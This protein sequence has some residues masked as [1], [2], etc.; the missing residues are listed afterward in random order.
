MRNTINIIS[1]LIIFSA[2][3]NIGGTTNYKVDESKSYYKEITRLKTIANIGEYNSE[4]TILVDFSIHSGKKR[5]FL[6]N[7]KSSKIEKSFLVAHGEGCN[8]NARTPSFSNTVGSLC[9][10]EGFGVL[11]GRAYSGWG[12]HIK[13]W[14]D[15]L[16]SSN[17][18][19]RRRVVVLHS[20]E[21]IPDEETYPFTI[22]KSQGC[23]TVSNNTMRYLDNLIKTQNNK[24]ILIYSFK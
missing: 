23:F 20:W 15:G 16:E 12:I 4:Y 19:M 11:G 24:K 21:G 22:A 5:M 7:L 13:Y 1:L 8:S 3:I 2:Y 10:S 14:I 9:S 6:Y 18:N 17:D